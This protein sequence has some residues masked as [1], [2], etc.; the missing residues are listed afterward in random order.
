VKRIA[1]VTTIQLAAAAVSIL[2][3]L[4]FWLTNL[5]KPSQDATDLA[6]LAAFGA[7]IML[8]VSAPLAAA[9]RT[10]WLAAAVAAT[11]IVG[12][13]PRIVDAVTRHV[14]DVARQREDRDIEVK[15]LIPFP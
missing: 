8:T 12:F 7:V 13:A 14:T 5:L 15:L 1:V 10:R 2:N 11:L 6:L 9:K 4:D 3:L